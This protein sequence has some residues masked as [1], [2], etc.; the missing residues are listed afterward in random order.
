MLSDNLSYNCSSVNSMR[1]NNNETL[2]I[3]EKQTS[4]LLKLIANTRMNNLK[5][6]TGNSLNNYRYNEFLK[7]ICLY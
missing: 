4:S 3:N 6:N 7:K 2:S 1:K 5:N